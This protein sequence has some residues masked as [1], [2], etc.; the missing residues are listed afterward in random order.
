[1][2]ELEDSLNDPACLLVQVEGFADEKVS[3]SIFPIALESDYV[4]GSVDWDGTE[5]CSSIVRAEN[6][7][8][9]ELRG[10]LLV[11][12]STGE[13]SLC[14]VPILGCGRWRSAQLTFQDP[15]G[16]SGE[17]VTIRADSATWQ[18]AV[19]WSDVTR[20]EVALPVP[21]PFRGSNVGSVLS[22]IASSVLFGRLP[23]FLDVPAPSRTVEKR[24]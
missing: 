7:E 5:V 4:V 20:T 21:E 15:A 2:Q 24:E 8:P 9:P 10:L 1:M 18:A 17:C 12:A 23:A 6:A 13:N 3:A 11:W 14:A 22:A 16:Q 19:T